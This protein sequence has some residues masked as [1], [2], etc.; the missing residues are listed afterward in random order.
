MN[1][2][3]KKIL[4]SI[5][6]VLA[7][8]AFTGCDDLLDAVPKDRLT[9]DTFFKNESELKAFAIVFYEAFPESDLYVANDDHYTQNNMSNEEMGKRTIPASGGGWSWGALRNI[10]TLLEDLDHCSNSAVRT[11]YEALAR[12]FRAYFYFNKVKR[13]GDVPWYDKTLGST[14]TEALTRERDNREF[15]EMVKKMRL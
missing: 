8:F 14:D 5:L 9:S 3:M 12:F 15:I 7:G 1:P 2:A 13:F 10:N 11:K 4:F 6:I